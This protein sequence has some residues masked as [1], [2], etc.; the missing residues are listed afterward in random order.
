[1]LSF[2]VFVPTTTEPLSISDKWFVQIYLNANLMWV[3]QGILLE[4]LAYLDV[5]IFSSLYI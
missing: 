5:S 4:A 1:M 3:Q 2:D